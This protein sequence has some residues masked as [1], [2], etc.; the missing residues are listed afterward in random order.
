M[1]GFEFLISKTA[2]AWLEALGYSVLHGAERFV[3]EF[4]P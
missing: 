3:T 1:N 4:T 2:L